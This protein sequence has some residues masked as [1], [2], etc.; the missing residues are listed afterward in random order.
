M[1]ISKMGGIPLKER[2]ADAV[3]LSATVIRE[4]KKKRKKHTF[5]LTVKAIDSL[6]LPP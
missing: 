3:L 2:F 4:K 5:P 1:I 6:A